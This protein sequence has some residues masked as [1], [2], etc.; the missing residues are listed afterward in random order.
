LSPDRHDAAALCSQC[1]GFLLDVDR[2]GVLLVDDGKLMKNAM[3]SAIGEW[4]E[5]YRKKGQELLRR[6]SESNRLIPVAVNRAC[7]QRGG[8]C[9]AT[10]V[11]AKSCAHD[12][13]VTPNSCLCIADGPLCQLEGAVPL[14]EFC[15]TLPDR[16]REPTL[17]YGKPDREK[18]ERQVLAPVF[19]TAKW[20]RMVD[21]HIGANAKLVGMDC[22]LPENYV[23]GLDWVTSC[24]AS[25]SDKRRL[26]EVT[27][28]TGYPLDLNSFGRSLVRKAYEDF[29]SAL[30]TRFE[31]RMIL[32]LLDFGKLPHQRYLLTDQV[33][34]DMGRG[35]DPIDRSGKLRDVSVSLLSARELR[36]LT[37]DY[38]FISAAPSPRSGKPA[39]V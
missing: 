9:D 2:N 26:S 34:L 31:V 6:L 7:D 36:K 19:R 39:F 5:K 27:I 3:A 21:R 23:R 32:N 14:A 37:A 17:I 38:P 16:F 4:P 29:V 35:Y 12:H 8:T 18:F 24:L 20:V 1:L 10:E 13:L 30:S 11:I 28:V 22:P 25:F 15:V 33:A